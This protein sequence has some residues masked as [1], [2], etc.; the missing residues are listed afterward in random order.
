MQKLSFTLD[1]LRIKQGYSEFLVSLQQHLLLPLKEKKLATNRAVDKDKTRQVQKGKL[2]LEETQATCGTL[3][4]VLGL[5]N[6][7]ELHNFVIE[8]YSLSDAFRHNC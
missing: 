8:S 2:A 4:L 7:V 5:L 3:N 1:G 6:Y